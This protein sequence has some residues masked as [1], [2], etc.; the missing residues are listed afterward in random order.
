MHSGFYV[1]KNAQYKDIGKRK[2]ENSQWS[3]ADPGRGEVAALGSNFI[4][5]H[6]VFGRNLAK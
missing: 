5:I 4:H 3:L 1:S 2:V 6:A